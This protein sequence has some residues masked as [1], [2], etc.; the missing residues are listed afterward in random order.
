MK[1]EG[2]LYNARVDHMF[3]WINGLP[4]MR[5]LGYTTR[6]VPTD[7]SDLPNTLILIT[8]LLYKFGKFDLKV[9]IQKRN[10]NL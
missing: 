10:S 9:G 5:P 7:L 4:I 8:I 1:E 2:I 3:E 6:L